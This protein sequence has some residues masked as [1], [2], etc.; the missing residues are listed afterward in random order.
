MELYCRIITLAASSFNS[1]AAVVLSFKKSKIE[2]DIKQ[3]RDF[4]D[5]LVGS[6]FVRPGT[7]HPASLRQRTIDGKD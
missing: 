5:D 1:I 4:R 6:L 7:R 3:F 2:R